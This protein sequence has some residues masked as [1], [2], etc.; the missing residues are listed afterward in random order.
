MWWIIRKVSSPDYTALMHI[1]FSKLYIFFNNICIEK[2]GCLI[3]KNH[4][5]KAAAHWQQHPLS[6]SSCWTASLAVFVENTINLHSHSTETTCKINLDLKPVVRLCQHP[7]WTFSY[8]FFV[9]AQL[10]AWALLGDR[11][12]WLKDGLLQPTEWTPKY[13]TMIPHSS[14]CLA[15]KEHS[16]EAHSTRTRG[17]TATRYG[18]DVTRSP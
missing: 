5:R 1:T 13:A 9:G 8:I 15:G 11:E 2:T 14:L 18:G 3:K 12:V 4:W 10:F 7:R 17:G 16:S 6:A